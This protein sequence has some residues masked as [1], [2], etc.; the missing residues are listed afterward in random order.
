[1]EFAGT[2]V[3]AWWELG[4]NFW[5]IGGSLLGCWPELAGHWEVVGCGELVQ[6]G[7]IDMLYLSCFS[8]G[9]LELQ[10]RTD[11]ET[12]RAKDQRH[13]CLLVNIL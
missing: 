6:G 9:A 5:G 10:Y 13:R 7:T 3:G 8:V 12:L 4:G 1:M 11:C 2:L